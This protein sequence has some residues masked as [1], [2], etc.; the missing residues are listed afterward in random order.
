M[1]LLSIRVN[2]VGFLI[3]F[4]VVHFDETSLRRKLIEDVAQGDANREEFPELGYWVC[5]LARIGDCSELDVITE[6]TESPEAGTKGRA[7]LIKGGELVSTAW[8][9]LSVSVVFVRRT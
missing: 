3:V 4:R 6:T 2:F 9:C 1:L 8:R 7:L 5:R